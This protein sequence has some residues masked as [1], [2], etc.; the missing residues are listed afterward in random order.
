MQQNQD[1]AAY[2]GNEASPA[3]APSGRGGGRR[4][5]LGQIALALAIFAGGFTGGAA[6]LYLAFER[7]ALDAANA[8]IERYEQDIAALRGHLEDARNAAAAL[9]GRFMVEE[10][11]RRGLESGLRATQEELG[12]ARDTIAFYEQLMPPGPK[13]AVSVRALDIE[14]AGPH[15]KYRVLLMRSGSNDKSF[16]GRLQ[17]VATGLQ[18][19]REVTV[20]LLP[21]TVSPVPEPA[22]STPVKA[23]AVDALALEFN[24]FQRSSGLLALPPGFV[25]AAVTVNVL[26]GKTLRVSRSIE[27]P[28]DE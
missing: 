25:P 18:D 2:R 8:R 28:L 17:F 22:D 3:A 12:R 11:T 27:L 4:H 1:P 24:D 16:Q 19:G 21:G 9:E 26:E 6:W 15:L 20:E 13:G 5:I 7:P 10:S 23:A 14:R